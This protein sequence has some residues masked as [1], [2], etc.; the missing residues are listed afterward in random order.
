M[1]GAAREARAAAATQAALAREMDVLVA[2]YLREEAG[3]KKGRAAVAELAAACAAAEKERAAWAAEEGVAVKQLA[4][5]KAARD[6][7]QREGVRLAGSLREVLASAEALEAEAGE[8][9]AVA[10][11]G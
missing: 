6:L 4:A 11:R 1:E 2:Q 3:E 5:L 10:G 8:A 9:Q 7:K